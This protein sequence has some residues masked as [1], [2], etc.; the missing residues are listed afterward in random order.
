MEGP[1]QL[2]GCRGGRERAENAA[3][4]YPDP[5]PDFAELQGHIAFYAGRVDA[6]YL[7][8]ELVRP[9]EGSFYGGWVTS[10]IEGPY[11]GEPGTE[12]W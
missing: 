4:Y 1:R 10:E 6:A 3:W 5:R 11:K 9:Q 2:P 7:D 12:S 8:D